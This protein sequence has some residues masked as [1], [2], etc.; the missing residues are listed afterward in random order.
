MVV[1]PLLI[2]LLY[3]M[4]GRLKMSL[5]NELDRQQHKDTDTYSYLHPCIV[6]SEEIT[7]TQMKVINIPQDIFVA[8]VAILSKD[9]SDGGGVG[10]VASCASV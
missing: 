4:A 8:I 10:A 6:K 7:R 9:L 5:W 1:G 2:L 3:R